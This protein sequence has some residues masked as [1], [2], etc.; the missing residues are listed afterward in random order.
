MTLKIRCDSGDVWTFSAERN[1]DKE[2]WFHLFAGPMSG[3][4]FMI[5]NAARAL[6]A[7]LIEAADA[8]DSPKL[9]RMVVTE[10]DGPHRHGSR[11]P[12]VG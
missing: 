2:V 4:V 3:G 8:V 1:D 9:P 5:P 7:E 12:D 11:F 6:S 10:S